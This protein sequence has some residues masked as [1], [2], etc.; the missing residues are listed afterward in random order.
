MTKVYRDGDTVLIKGTIKETANGNIAVIFDDV[1]LS[2][3]RLKFSNAVALHTETI[4]PG[5][6]VNRHG[7]TYMEEIV[8][9]TVH[10][11][12][13]D[14][15]FVETGKRDPQFLSV[16]IHELTRINDNVGYDIEF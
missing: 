2:I 1:Y 4:L 12:A 6:K 13:N 8:R 16:P 10:C 9:G 7:S 11:V 14:H 3:D 5:D 15:A